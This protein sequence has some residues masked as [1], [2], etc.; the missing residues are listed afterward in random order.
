MWPAFNAPLSSLLCCRRFPPLDLA[1]CECR[2]G[3]IPLLPAQVWDKRWSL[4][5]CPCCPSLSSIRGLNTPPAVPHSS[6]FADSPL[7][8]T[9]QRLR[10]RP[11]VLPHC[12]VLRRGIIPAR[13]RPGHYTAGKRPRLVLLGVLQRPT[14]SAVL[15]HI[16][17]HF[18][19]WTA[20][21]SAYSDCDPALGVLAVP[22]VSC[23]DAV[24]FICS[25]RL[26]RALCLEW[27]GVV[28]GSL[29]GWCGFC[30][31]CDFLF[32]ESSGG[33]GGGQITFF[34]FFLLFFFYLD[35][36]GST[37]VVTLITRMLHKHCI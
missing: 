10:A 32:L 17:S 2:T 26:F 12:N 20:E 5:H 15:R 13:P 7:P 34:F 30:W 23:V 21:A 29:V 4:P 16:V 27:G 24:S 9:G 18:L 22:G 33:V 14:H 31:A 6:S 36:R 19:R 1:H 37:N 3:G 11:C 8:A 35:M 28:L 25:L